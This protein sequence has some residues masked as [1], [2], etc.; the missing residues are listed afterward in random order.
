MN[1]LRRL[2]PAAI[3]A[4][5][6][7]GTLWYVTEPPSRG[8][9]ENPAADATHAPFTIQTRDGPLALDSLRGQ[10]VVVYFGYT[11]CP[12]VCPTTLASMAAAFRQLEPQQQKRVTLLF[13]SVDPE[14]DDLERLAA[15][16][17]YFHPRFIGGTAPPGAIASIARDWGVRFAK[18]A[19]GNSSMAYTV[20]H[21]THAFLVGPDGRLLR[22][23]PHG[24][25]PDTI[26]AALRAAI[27]SLPAGTTRRP[28]GVP[29]R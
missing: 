24:L 9:V 17:R 28:D 14:R 5:L 27:G 2:L 6:A 22:T 21:T 16:A 7:M 13:V 19:Q 3:A 26:A 8:P 10:V 15:Y 4:A 23:F 20:D 25:P 18:V 12:D 11:S 29:A 1:A